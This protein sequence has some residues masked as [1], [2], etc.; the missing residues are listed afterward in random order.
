MSSKSLKARD[1]LLE[2]R[3]LSVQAGGAEG[4]PVPILRGVDLS[5]YPGEAHGLVGESGS[6]KTTLGRALLRLQSHSQFQMQGEIWFQGQD[7]PALAEREMRR[8]RG[9]SIAYIPQDA[10]SSLN[11]HQRIASQF[12]E[13]LWVHT[14]LDAGQRRQRAQDSLKEVGLS[15][16]R[17]VLRAYPHQLSVGMAQRVL[18]A[19]ALAL[20]PQLLLADEPTSSLDI[21]SSDR[22]TALLADLNRTSGLTILLITHDFEVLFKVA[23]RVSVMY[24]GE[25]VEQGPMQLLRRQPSHPYTRALLAARM[26]PGAEGL[27]IAGEAPEPRALPPG[28]VFHPRCPEADALCSR[29]HPQETALGDDHSVRCLRREEEAP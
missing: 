24:G 20:K 7:L 2:V 21:V 13:M 12:L 28:C 23:Q 27:A 18:I 29:Q 26:L 10:Q 9:P 1:P 4:P 8:L 3:Q 17:Q 6:G 22:V 11:P 16:S 14:A 5:I 25:I 19:M 15:E